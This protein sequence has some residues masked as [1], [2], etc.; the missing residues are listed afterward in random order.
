MYSYCIPSKSQDIENFKKMTQILKNF[1][2]QGNYEAMG[3]YG[4]KLFEEHCSIS[5][6]FHYLKSAVKNGEACVTESYLKI[7]HEQAIEEIDFQ[8]EMTELL[9]M[10]NE[11]TCP[12]LTYNYERTLQKGYFQILIFIQQ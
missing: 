6:A 1:A 11:E 8:K 9:K 4:E 7:I 5:E 3:F 2:D 10:I 12:C